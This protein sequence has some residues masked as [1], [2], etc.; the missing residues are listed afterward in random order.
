V[1]E[2]AHWL[3]TG[4]SVRGTAF[5]PMAEVIFQS[6][7]HLARDDAL[8]MAVYLKSLPVTRGVAITPA[9]APE[10][11][12]KMI[13]A[14]RGRELYL[15]HCAACHG[16]QGEGKPGAYPTLVG[17]R[18]LLMTNTANLFG[19]LLSGGFAPATAG[20]PR[21][22]GMPPFYHLL[23]DDDMAALLSYVRSAWGNSAPTITTLDLI[24]YRDRL[25]SVTATR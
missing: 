14:G 19:V 22:H 11:S 13:A 7:Q 20:N 6:T 25:R 9:L 18:T 3:Q 16:K 5:G 24:H 12:G 4:V 21:P 1:E 10:A 8:A 15:G 2:I 23:T 17:N